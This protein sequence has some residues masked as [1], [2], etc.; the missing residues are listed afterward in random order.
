[1]TQTHMAHELYNKK[2][3]ITIMISYRYYKFPRISMFIVY[4]KIHV[5][6]FMT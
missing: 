2:Y 6:N 1:M 4:S 5:Q 3:V